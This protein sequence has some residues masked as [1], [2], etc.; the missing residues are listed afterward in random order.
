[1]VNMSLAALLFVFGPGSLIAIIM[2]WRQP[3]F[4][5][6]CLSTLAT[7]AGVALYL[8]V[9]LAFHTPSD[10]DGFDSLGI[11]VEFFAFC[12]FLRCLYTWGVFFSCSLLSRKTSLNEGRP[13]LP[14]RRNDVAANGFRPQPSEPEGRRTKHG[15][16]CE[17]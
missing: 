15:C 11:A 3:R 17:K 10:A 13:G 12:F 7:T 9:R 4:W 2:W 16:R 5:W 1:M 6:A 14:R 8:P